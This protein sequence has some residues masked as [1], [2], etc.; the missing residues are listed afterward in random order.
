MLKAEIQF[1]LIKKHIYKGKNETYI[2]YSH[3]VQKK[4]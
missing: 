4:V 1:R 2:L 3:H